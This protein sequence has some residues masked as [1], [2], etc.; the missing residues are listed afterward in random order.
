MIHS[1]ARSTA[2]LASLCSVPPRNGVYKSETFIGRGVKL[3][4]MG[5]LFSRDVIDSTQTDFQLLDLTDSERDRFLLENDDLLFSRTSV[6]ASG[7]GKCSIARIAGHDEVA[8]DSNMV[9]VRLS[10]TK[11]WPKYLFYYFL[12]PEGR[13]SVRSVASGAAVTALKGSDLA[14]LQVPAPSVPTQRKI[15][16]IL[17]AYDNLIENNLR[18]IKILEEMV[19]NLYREWFVKFRFPGSETCHFVDSPIGRIPEG[20]MVTPIVGIG[21]LTVGGDWGA[22]EP[23]G[24]D[25][26]QAACL[27][28]VDLHN[29]QTTGEGEPVVRWVSKSS[30]AKRCV[31]PTDVVVE[32][33]GECGR[34]LHGY[35]GLE[36]SL[37]YAVIY[38]NF[39]K[40]LRFGKPAIAQYVARVLN[41]MVETGAIRQYR[42]GTAIP[43][44]NVTAL[45]EKHLLLLPPGEL[46]AQFDEL[47]GLAEGFRLRGHNR[48]LRR[49]RDLLLPKL[50]SG[51]VDVS[52]L[53][54]ALPEEAMT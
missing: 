51:E 6:K 31:L 28:G 21:E 1:T 46:L 40:R 26:V 37:G 3:V 10:K 49:T 4:R 7:I 43:N 19:Q 33:S 50:I 12:S 52:E 18:R 22:G 20:W 8:F 36:D 34:S 16:T 32:G 53:D 9:R 2:E 15:A 5:E 11:C 29:L 41:E 14:R 42:T 39:C 23:S 13:D 35:R 27:R 17:S 47:A 48:S 54:I 25:S 44:L 45:V 38:S 30:L 24:P